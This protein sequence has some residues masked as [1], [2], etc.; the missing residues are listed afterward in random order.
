MGRSHPVR[1][2]ARAL[3]SHFGSLTAIETASVDELSAVDGVGAI[4]ASSLVE[5]LEVDWHRDIVTRWRAAGVP[6]EIPGHPGPGAA[7]E[8]LDGPLS[9][10]VVVITGPMPGYTRDSAEEAVRQ[11]GGTVTSSVSVKTT[12]VFVGGDKPSSKQAKAEELGIRIV[13]ADDFVAS[14]GL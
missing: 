8:T 2:L 4:I 5:W 14:L 3:A 1:R 9:G 12:L 10:E 13:P 6:F 7:L 11:A